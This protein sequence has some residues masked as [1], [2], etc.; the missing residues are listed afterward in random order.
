MAAAA[1]IVHRRAAHRPAQHTL[2]DELLRLLRG[3]NHHLLRSAR[4][5]HALEDHN[6]ARQ[7]NIDDRDTDEV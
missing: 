6:D 3:G 1:G 5:S 4:D 2:I 7:T